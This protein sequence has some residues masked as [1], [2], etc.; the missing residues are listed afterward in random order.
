MAAL[1]AI[2]LHDELT[3]ETYDRRHR[4]PRSPCALPG[5]APP[6][7]GIVEV[8]RFGGPDVLG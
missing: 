3:G 2:V 6:A 1:V 4:R 8:R 7:G 5:V